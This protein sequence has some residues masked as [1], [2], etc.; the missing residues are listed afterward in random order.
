MRTSR[1][2]SIM[3]FYVDSSS[4]SDTQHPF[5]RDR[6]ISMLQQIGFTPIHITYDKIYLGMEEYK[7]YDENRRYITLYTTDSMTVPILCDQWVLALY[8]ILHTVMHSSFV[9]AISLLLVDIRMG[10]IHSMI[11][12]WICSLIVSAVC[13]IPTCST[14]IPCS[15]FS[16]CSSSSTSMPYRLRK[17]VYL[18]LSKVVGK[19]TS[20]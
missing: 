10:R 5:S 8:L 20:I 3:L 1:S 7:L 12:P 9:P 15:H 6:C 4:L 16:T 18:S 17:I 2:N 19:L 13:S 14:L 11:S